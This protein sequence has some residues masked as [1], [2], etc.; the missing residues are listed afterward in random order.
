MKVGRFGHEFRSRLRRCLL[1]ALSLLFSC[2]MVHGVDVAS[3]LIICLSGPNG[4]TH[5]AMPT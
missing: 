4:K 3:F 1:P 2:S 5:I